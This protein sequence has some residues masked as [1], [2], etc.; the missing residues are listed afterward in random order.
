[1]SFSIFGVFFLFLSGGL[2]IFISL[3]IEPILAYLHRKRQYGQYAYLEWVTN[4]SLQLQ[5]LAHEEIGWGTWSRTEGPVPI[6]QEGQ[7][8]ACL[9]LKDIKHPRLCHSSESA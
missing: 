9:D 5:R 7:E 2:I 4:E 1:M 6:V 8:L 3:I